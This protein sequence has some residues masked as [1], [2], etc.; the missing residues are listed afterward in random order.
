MNEHFPQRWIGRNSPLIHWPPRSPDLTPMDFYF[1]GHIKNKVY[2][3]RPQS[4]EQLCERIRQAC[5]EVTAQE[6]RRVIIYRGGISRGSEKLLL[7]K[8]LSIS[9][10]TMISRKLRFSFYRS[11]PAF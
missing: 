2:K 11:R 8:F 1:W 9:K 10:P 5:L 4:V 7:T 6:L 3:T